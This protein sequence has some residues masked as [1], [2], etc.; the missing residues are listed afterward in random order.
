[1]AGH[2]LG[3]EDL[4]G[5]KGRGDGG[6]QGGSRAPGLCSG[7]PNTGHQG[8]HA[9]VRVARHLGINPLCPDSWQ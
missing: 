3:S 9:E 2:W 1:M 4:T 5:G 6:H 8:G 7:L